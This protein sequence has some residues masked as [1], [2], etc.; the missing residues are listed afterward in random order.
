M[1]QA[2]L[3]VDSARTRMPLVCT[4]ISVLVWTVFV[5]I[6]FTSWLFS[7]TSSAPDLQG[8]KSVQI[9]QPNTS[10]TTVSEAKAPD[11][12]ASDW[13]DRPGRKF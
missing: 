1:S 10:A 13:L 2:M 8:V 9:P 12:F 7:T 5:A 4:V 3:H 6:C 11:P